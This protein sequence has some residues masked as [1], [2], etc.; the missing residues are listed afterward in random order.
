MPDLQVLLELSVLGA[1]RVHRSISRNDLELARTE[2]LTVHRIVHNVGQASS[3]I[4]L[5]AAYSVHDTIRV[6]EAHYLSHPDTTAKQRMAYLSEID[7][8]PPIRS[9][10]EVFD[11]VE[12]WSTIDSLDFY[13]RGI[14]NPVG[15]DEFSTDRMGCW[16]HA[17]YQLIFAAIVDWSDIN[18]GAHAIYDLIGDALEMP[19]G[20]DRKKAI[21][22]L[23]P[24]LCHY[25]YLLPEETVAANN[26]NEWMTTVG[27][28]A[29]MQRE[30]RGFRLGKAFAVR[31]L[32]SFQ[33]LE[34]LEQMY[35]CRVAMLP[36][37]IAVMSDFD[38]TGNL[39]LDTIGLRLPDGRSLD[40]DSFNGEPYR[41]NYGWNSITIYSVGPDGVD[42]GGQ[43]GELYDGTYAD[44]E[45]LRF[46]YENTPEKVFQWELANARTPFWEAEIPRQWKGVGIILASLSFGAISLWLR[47]RKA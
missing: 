13:R 36:A 10:S 1:A 37:L 33:S 2:L 15:T 43:S 9:A 32:R 47:R 19:A 40:V 3:A 6:A 12:R 11:S 28:F 7:R 46:E 26:L 31:H 17:F 27:R 25:I 39:R 5:G 30:H 45:Y 23:I 38:R 42:H 21:E 20:L 35:Q 44:D 24:V 14:L 18:I 8:L 34:S 41:I 22:E 16:Q 29:E 4:Q